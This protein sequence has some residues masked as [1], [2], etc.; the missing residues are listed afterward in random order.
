MRHLALAFAL[1]LS[2]AGAPSF[3]SAL[4]NDEFRSL[5]RSLQSYQGNQQHRRE[6]IA[7]YHNRKGSI[8][9]VCE[10]DKVHQV[11]KAFAKLNDRASVA[12]AYQPRRS[13]EIATIQFRRPASR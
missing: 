3:A 8:A 6:L 11:E 10:Y 9:A 13:V 5:L 7:E 2:F 4:C 12:P 1:L